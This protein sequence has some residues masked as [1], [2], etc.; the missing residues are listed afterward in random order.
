[1]AEFFEGKII[2]DQSV[3]LPNMKDYY[4]NSLKPFINSD[5]I[6]A[7]SIHYVEDPPGGE[8]AGANVAGTIF[9]IKLK[10]GATVTDAVVLDDESIFIGMV[11]GQGITVDMSQMTG[12][13]SEPN[14]QI[15]NQ[16]TSKEKLSNYV[17]GYDAE[18]ADKDNPLSG[19]SITNKIIDDVIICKL[20]YS[21]IPTTDRYSIKLIKKDEIEEYEY[22]EEASF[23]A[24]VTP[25]IPEF[26]LDNSSGATYTA[27]SDYSQTYKNGDP[28][29][30]YNGKQVWKYY[31]C[32][33]NNP[34]SGELEESEYAY[35][36]TL[37]NR[38]PSGIN[39]NG[40]FQIRDKIVSA[41]KKAS[42]I[43]I[44]VSINSLNLSSE[45]FLDYIP[46]TFSEDNDAWWLENLPDEYVDTLNSV[47]N[48]N[49][50][51]YTGFYTYGH[52]KNAK[53]LSVVYLKVDLDGRGE[54]WI[55]LNKYAIYL[56][57]DIPFDVEI[58][59]VRQST[60]AEYTTAFDPNSYY[61]NQKA[62]QDNFYLVTDL[63]GQ[64]K[65][66][67][68]V[69][70]QAFKVAGAHLCGDDLKDWTVSIGDVTFF[71]PPAAIRLITQTQTERLPLMRARGTMSK[72]IEKSDSE[73]ELSLYFNCDSGINGVPVDTVLWNTRDIT[74]NGSITENAG[75]ITTYYMNGLRALL[76]EFRFTP[77]L[78]I[79]NK[80]INETLNIYAVS[81]E[82][83]GVQTVPNF[84]RLIQGIIRLKK[85][86]YNVYMPELPDPFYVDDG[87]TLINPFAEC[88]N[89][90]VMRYYYQK[91]ILYGN[92]IQAKLDNGDATGYTFNSTAFIEDTLFKNK[93]ALMPCKFM[94]P[95][96]DIYIAN[97]DHLQR[98]MSI[99]VQQINKKRTGVASTS[100][101]PN[102][103]QENFIRDMAGLNSVANTNNK[104]Q[105]FDDILSDYQSRLNNVISAVKVAYNHKYKNFNLDLRGVGLDHYKTQLAYGN[106]Q[107]YEAVLKEIRDNY[108]T[109]P[110]VEALQKSFS[111]YRNIDGQ[112]FFRNFIIEPDGTISMRLN[113]DYIGDHEDIETI[114]QT[115]LA[116]QNKLSSSIYNEVLKNNTFRI[117][118]GKWK[119][120]DKGLPPDW[121]SVSAYFKNTELD[122]LLLDWCTSYS[123]AYTYGNE[124]AQSLKEASDWENI[125]SIKFDLAGE[126]IRVD[127]FECQMKNNFSRI[128]LLDSD[129]YAPQYMGSQDIHITWKIT[130]KD[131]N[132][133]GLMRGLPEY[134]AY[135]MRKYHLVL[136]CF[137]I[138]I[139]SEF[140]RM[141]GVYEVSIEDTVV[142]T[143][144]NFPGLYEI[145]VRAISTDRTM[146]NREA[147]RS[148][149]NTDPNES[150]GQSG[151][152]NNENKSDKDSGLSSGQ[153]ATQTRI[154]GYSEL[155][156]KLASA[157]LYPDLE[158]PKIKELAN[159][160]FRFIRYKDKERDSVD[161]FVD[162]D[163]YFYYPHT[164]RAEV[165]RAN[166]ESRFG[167]DEPL[168]IGTTIL[169]DNSGA[170][171]EVN[172]NNVFNGKKI[173]EENVGNVKF[174]E[175]KKDVEKT[176][177]IVEE[178]KSEKRNFELAKIIP[179]AIMGDPDKWDVSPNITVSFMERSY[180][181]LCQLADKTNNN[182]IK[183]NS[184]KLKELED[185]KKFYDDKMIGLEQS[186]KAL[187]DELKNT[188]LTE[189]DYNSWFM[190]GAESYISNHKQNLINLYFGTISEVTGPNS[191]DAAIEGVRTI[192]IL[193][194]AG[195][196]V[197]TTY[198][199]R[200]DQ[201]EDSI[202]SL[203]NA[204]WATYTGL[205]EYNNELYNGQWQGRSD[206]YGEIKNDFGGYDLIKISDLDILDKSKIVT[207]G[208]F[209]IKRIS[210]ERLLD[211]LD[212]TEQTEFLK[213][214]DEWNN[215]NKKY[216]SF[217]L[218][219]YYRLHPELI[220]DY[221]YNCC[222]NKDFAK[223]AFMRIVLWWLLKLYDNKL[224]PSISLDVMR[225]N[226]FNSFEAKA[227]AMEL[228]KKE[229][230][231]EATIDIDANLI[232]NI[233]EFAEDNGAGLD[234]GKI[235]VAV[236]LALF[237]EPLKKNKLYSWMI[238]RNYD[239]LNSY[240]RSI[241]SYKY[242]ERSDVNNPDSRY[243]KFLYAL[244]GYDLIPD[245]AR[246]GIKKDAMPAQNYI[247]TRNTKIAIEAAKD[248]KQYIFHSFYDMVRGDYRG[249]MLRAFPTFY[250]VFMDEGKEIGLWKLHDN[251]Y[252][253]NA[254]HE[255][256]VTK[257]RKIAADTC[258]IVLSNNYSTFTTDDE[259][260]YINYQGSWSELWDSITQNKDAAERAAKQRLT[261][262]FVNR[263][264]L[265]PGIRIHVREGYGSDARELGTVFN[266]V[267]ASVTPGAQAVN[268]VAQG[269]GIE[270]MSPFLDDRDADEIQFQDNRD[271][272]L[273]NREGRGASPKTIL[274]SI[275]N[276]KGS[277]TSRYVNGKF[278][279]DQAF[280]NEF[281]DGFLDNYWSNPDEDSVT[282]AISN[283]IKEMYN[284]NPYGIRSFGDPNFTD[285]F[286]EGE[287]VQNLYDITELP[288]MDAIGSDNEPEDEDLV[289]APWISIETR[290][291]TMWDIMHICQS[292][293]PDYITSTAPFG[294]RDTI[295][296]GRPHYYYAYDY[297]TVNEATVEKRKPFQQFHFYFSDSDII[298]NSITAIANFP[299]VA[300]GLYKN[301]YGHFST[302]EDIGP[303][304]IDQQIYPERQRSVVVDTRLYMK[305]GAPWK[306]DQDDEYNST[307]NFFIDGL[308]DGVSNAFQSVAN[309]LLGDLYGL[310]SWATEDLFGW[311]FDEKGATSSH[312]KIAWSAT[313]N[314][315]KDGFK[316]MYQGSLIVMG[317]PT[318]KPYDRITMYDSYNDMVGQVLVR[319]V[320]H[321][322]N[323]QTGFTTTINVDAISV[324]DD[325]EEL[326]RQ[327][328]YSE[329]FGGI[330]RTSLLYMPA[331]KMYQR[332]AQILEKVGIK[333]G[334][335]VT[336]EAKAVADEAVAGGKNV[337]QAITYL[338]QARDTITNSRIVTTVR[339]LTN[340]ILTS[341]YLPYV[342]IAMG[343]ITITSC[344]LQ[345]LYWK[346]KN[347]QVLIIFPLKKNGLP[348]TAGLD[349]NQGLV[350]GSSTWNNV[351]FLEGLAEKYLSPHQDDSLFSEV[352][353]SVLSTDQ[354]ADVAARYNRDFNSFNTMNSDAL[355][356]QQNIESV[357]FGLLRTPEFN[358]QKSTIGLS[359]FPRAIVRDIQNT[360]Q[361]KNYV[362]AFDPYYIA[363]I[364]SLL[365]DQSR[366]N[367]M[368]ISNYYD[369]KP[370][371]EDNGF[372]EILHE[373]LEGSNIDYVTHDIV[374]EKKQKKINGIT[375]VETVNGKE[376]KI[377]DVPYLSKDALIVLTDIVKEA[378]KTIYSNNPND[379]IQHDI[380]K[381]TD[382]IILTSALR[383][384]SP[385]KNTSSGYSFTIRGTG[386][387]ESQLKV[388]IEG[389]R[390]DIKAKLNT[391]ITTSKYE[392]FS[393]TL[394]NKGIEDY[395]GEPYMILNNNEP[396][397]AKSEITTENFYRLSFLDNRRAGTAIACFSSQD[398][399][400]DQRDNIYIP[401]PGYEYNKK[402]SFIKGEYLY[403]RCHLLRHAFTG[404]NNDAQNLVTGTRQMN[405]DGMLVFEN[406]VMDTMKANP[407]L[408]IMYRVTPYYAGSNLVCSG[409]QMEAL[410][411]ED[412]G[413]A[414]K[415]NVFC[416]NVQPGVIIDY[417]TGNNKAAEEDI[418]PSIATEQG[419]SVNELEPAFE[420]VTYNNSSDI[421][422]NV[423]PPT[424]LGER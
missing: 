340:P 323:A 404:N 307:G 25:Y 313:A 382:K 85:L 290:G 31:D 229:Y 35:Y 121:A 163:F 60:L 120:F 354:I 192:P 398:I 52:D 164:I 87:K 134:E 403:N 341:V 174:E 300:T 97:E 239:A 1:M 220:D 268:I 212:S 184:D 16:L 418:T 248:P 14:I 45:Q 79:V 20:M 73:L 387:L 139:D 127:S 227:R 221:L 75:P 108:I 228:I 318:V 208:I 22:K 9:T 260:G 29:Y 401:V 399:N 241:V 151:E 77:F 338:K 201:F 91:P 83:I 199:D 359:I 413:E 185:L 304:W 198:E 133:A 102:D 375:S 123:K 328:W 71:I 324:V 366:K 325:R 103:L 178:S 119:I 207:A 90:D 402:Y 171:L 424:P 273:N 317:D 140:T 12:G 53:C 224:F 373:H 231:E 86:D 55:N 180:L 361:V 67:E 217:V 104:K 258:T 381:S 244:V 44:C 376:Y 308:F 172:F 8:E 59:S 363:N 196:L 396:N 157:E 235:F 339:M 247:S 179:S 49:W 272:Q 112:L 131:A 306:S 190:D 380:E 158:L 124:E 149:G 154:R 152:L 234:T 21:S 372:L 48:D 226:A 385:Y 162:P 81:L 183:Q 137:P 32:N 245:I 309:T 280:F 333:I 200:L 352:V 210:K 130:T 291:K 182:T 400:N 189:D 38:G 335:A 24:T 316:D 195:Q 337:K 54:Q 395:N 237:D 147:L 107:E 412:N 40:A 141:I 27:K 169:T 177:A 311:L 105:N 296:L 410:S 47:F 150:T 277:T 330:V 145:T 26:G 334:G 225:I 391:H 18:Y 411:V 256:V 320:T 283:W 95:N 84:P 30:I 243:R 384:G 193:G 408:H 343:V 293:G 315:L 114:I 389:F 64:N 69:Q 58:D 122:E 393:D 394:K 269:N 213:A 78:P 386:D 89:Y 407:N 173:V 100:F 298:A 299:T 211:F 240:I 72:N 125:K 109:K 3:S 146:R 37:S 214:I 356:N 365:S 390:K 271:T 96:I 167:G 110:L 126:N 253:M 111:D 135:C 168:G 314:A 65:R 129:G 94:D 262:R 155:N 285:I 232:D 275:L 388:I 347:M 205:Y 327:S 74:N 420:I 63:I 138:R 203:I 230:G 266:G 4:H 332:G 414:V 106:E 61:M 42:D 353:Q 219:P 252:S 276:T 209:K 51:R 409:V 421:R 17:V 36:M 223:A 216:S 371:I 117:Y 326:S 346:I 319:D 156:E 406:K 392:K 170:K 254:I 294:F 302:N 242:K 281:G 113:V 98:L 136:P 310:G 329:L 175:R 397:F 344:L 41:I 204:A 417:A 364:E 13:D 197:D 342:L 128:S 259:D 10:N 92:E 261:A 101:E 348:Y 191:V 186:I 118:L 351:G 215:Q 345:S 350:Y 148:L 379:S 222:K 369:L 57:L 93:T 255:I 355:Y 265:Q 295:F 305:D 142:N 160:G 82:E 321:I 39:R 287:T 383:V 218:D 132:F 66:R 33:R 374:V 236:S 297:T 194:T 46:T 312:K 367:N 115:A 144:P 70:N 56:S 377:E 274:A 267:I 249:R 279:E 263:A 23:N 303:L 289:T 165:I 159:L 270:L 264:K 301:K 43:R 282:N 62:W 6:T 288:Y 50:Y 88:I 416:Y 360:Q 423:N 257:S 278:D 116:G 187:K 368:L 202:E 246:V 357:S 7:Q 378:R 28:V 415:F 2:N 166:L 322:L 206:Y 76:S 405:V 331:A 250:C 99:K 188:P 153:S 362:K 143:V 419:T 15:F 68:E 292:V 336:P 349:G 284:G 233:K 34:N 251:F 422:I 5:K 176:R 19:Y 181:N 11:D 238:A 286:P 370:F 80:Y 358:R 161:L